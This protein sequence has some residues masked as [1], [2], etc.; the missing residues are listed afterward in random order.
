MKLL[1]INKIN[2]RDMLHN[3]AILID[4]NNDQRIK[5]MEKMKQ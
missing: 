3:I 2:I 5:L 1:G 4:C